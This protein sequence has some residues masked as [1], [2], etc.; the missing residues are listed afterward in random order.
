[1]EK[2]SSSSL[3][4]LYL[5]LIDVYHV[6]CQ[7]NANGDVAAG[8]TKLVSLDASCG[9]TAIH[10]EIVFEK[11]FDGIIY[12]KGAFYTP[13]CVYI[14]PGSG[15]K[16]Y[17]F[18]IPINQCGTTENKPSP[19]S[20]KGERSFENTLVMQNDA[21]F[22][23]ILDVVRRI[24]C[25]TASLYEKIVDFS[26]INVN[27]KDVVTASFTSDDVK[28]SID[29]QNGRGP[30]SPSLNQ[31]FIQ[32]GDTVTLVV[33]MTAE[34][35]NWDVHVRE[36]VAMDSQERASLLLQDKRGC[37][38]KPKIMSP[39]AITRD[40]KNPKVQI[41]YS[42]MKAFRFPDDMQVQIKCVVAVCRDECDRPES[43]SAPAAKGQL[44]T[45]YTA[46]ASNQTD[47]EYDTSADD[48]S[49]YPVEQTTLPYTAAGKGWKKQPAKET[50]VQLPVLTST[51]LKSRRKRQ[52]N[53]ADGSAGVLP[54]KRIFN[55]I[56]PEDI[57]NL[58]NSSVVFM[59]AS[60]PAN[61]L[62]VNQAM[63]IVLMAFL[64]ILIISTSVA[65]TITCIRNR[66]LRQAEKAVHVNF[67]NYTD[68]RY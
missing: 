45:P 9:A 37:I 8:P 32:I 2:F 44:T 27:M 6:L 51:M 61:A 31:G 21:H 40:K 62:C 35:G 49:T 55:V 58:R 25:S 12:S 54:V 42:F 3:I 23:D 57:A 36:C 15:E 13:Q 10:V 52:A 53:V 28:V 19:D 18:D 46:G 66:I 33:Y 67:D 7:N 4:T 38:S 24:R 17:S 20:K 14:L 30:F 16:E 65:L 11:P 5:L 68:Q 41:A 34:S 64:F 26:P 22:Q 39:F 60:I 48:E 59:D 47:S 63:F 43:C 50:S 1:M 29:V 56:S